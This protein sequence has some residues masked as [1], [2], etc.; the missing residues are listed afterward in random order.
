M[1]DRE[2]PEEHLHREEHPGDRSVEA[3]TD[4][5]AGSGG[6]QAPDLV[7]TEPGATGDRGTDRCSDLHDRT[8]PAGRSSGAERQ[9]SGDDLERGDPGGE[10][11]GPD[12]QPG[13]GLR[14]AVSGDL[15]RQAVPDPPGGQQAG[16]DC[17]QQDVPAGRGDIAHPLDEP[18]DEGDR[19]DEQGGSTADQ[20][21]DQEGQPEEPGGLGLPE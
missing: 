15:G 20:H 16:R 14:H 3:G 6:H 10:I 2:H 9:R 12:R 8:L 1:P 5:R 18:L 21:P 17:G 13:G 4:R 19:F 7:F 11:S